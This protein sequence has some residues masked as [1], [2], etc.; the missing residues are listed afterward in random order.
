[1]VE[2][3]ILTLSTLA[4]V[5]RIRLTCGHHDLMDIFKSFRF[6][7]SK[8]YFKFALLYMQGIKFLHASPQILRVISSTHS[9]H[10]LEFS[11]IPTIS[12]SF[13]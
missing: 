12:I 10:V 1:M 6:H 3:H 8:I 13:E 2:R 9:E 7:E 5:L 11:L 4:S